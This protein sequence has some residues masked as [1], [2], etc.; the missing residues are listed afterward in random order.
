[1]TRFGNGVSVQVGNI[2]QDTDHVRPQRSLSA[3]LQYLGNGTTF[4]LSQTAYF[5]LTTSSRIMTQSGESTSHARFVEETHLSHGIAIQPRIWLYMLSISIDH[6][7]HGHPSGLS[8]SLP[9]FSIILRQ[10]A[11]SQR[12]LAFGHTPYNNVS[13]E[14]RKAPQ[15]SPEERRQE[16][17]D[18]RQHSHIT[19]NIACVLPTLIGTGHLH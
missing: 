10:Q 9:R 14:R 15:Y 1:M 7:I 2:G 18:L 6:N 4:H 5:T 3:E 19:S 11:T 16:G 8:Q 12:C 13:G 17:I